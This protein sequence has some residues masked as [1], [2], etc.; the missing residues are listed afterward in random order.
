[1]PIKQVAIYG[2]GGIG[3]STIAA[4]IS[5]ALS[6]MGYRVMQ[7]GCDPKSDSTNTLRGGRFIP[8]VLD[9][10][11]Q[12]DRVK[13]ED[14]VHEGFNGILTIEV[15][16]PEPG[17][18]CAGRGILTAI[19]MIKEERAF[20]RYKPDLVIYDVLGD[21]V[22][23]GFAAPI[24]EGIAEQIYTVSSADYMALYAANNLF[25]GI[26]KYSKSGG[27]LLG[28]IIGNSINNPDEEELLI[29]FARRTRTKIIDFVPR[30]KR[31]RIC[32]LQGKTVIE[33]A[34]DSKQAEIY[35]KLA[36]KIIKNEDRNIPSPMKIEELQEWAAERLKKLVHD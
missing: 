10:L 24:R 26:R 3:K 33:C 29:D 6:T 36:K 13:I 8:T 19:K 30:S 11:R 15:G 34:P 22:C 25:K 14:V 4:H 31:V 23:G 17:V 35:R 18:G 1:M 27:A 32:E 16:G 20:E 9:T 7:I 5:A 28:G 12:R 2:K 21:V